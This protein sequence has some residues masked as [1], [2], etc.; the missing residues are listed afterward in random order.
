MSEHRGWTVVGAALAVFALGS[1]M[2]GNVTGVSPATAAA[3]TQ[4]G[5]NLAKKKAGKGTLK[6]VVSGTGTGTYTVTGKGFRRTGQ[7]SK[8]F[9]V[10]PGSYT[11]KPS[12]GSVKPGTV[13]VRK[14]KVSQ[15]KVAFPASVT[16]I[17]TATP[18]TPDPPVT[19]TPSPTTPT[20]DPPVTT[21]PSP[22]TPPPGASG[23]VQ[24]VSVDVLGGE[25]HDAST[26]G[27]WSPDG[28]KV[29]FDSSADNL[30][31]G[32]TNGVGDL[33]VKTLSSGAIQRVST[34]ATGAQ[35]NAASMGGSWSPD[36][37][38]I[39][40]YSSAG[41][42]VAGDTNGAGDLFVKTLSSG[43]IQRV[44]TDATGAQANGE[45]E[46]E[47]VWSPDGTKILFYSSAGNLVAGDTNGALDL[48]VK[49]LSSGAIQRVNTDAT[50]AQ[51]N[52]E[53]DPDGVWSPDG[54]KILFDSSASNLVAGDTNFQDDAF[55]KTLSSGAIQRISTDATGAQGNASSYIGP[56]SP[57]GAKVLF[58]S[59][60][61]NLVAGDTNG[62]GDLFVKTLSSG[63]VQRFNTDATGAQANA[64][65]MG[66]SWSPD[67][68][69]IFFH[70]FAGNLV[71][72]DTNGAIDVFVKTLSS[73]AVEWVSA[74]ATG[75]QESA[76]SWGISWS[77]DG[78]KILFDSSAG[79]LVAGDTNGVGDLFVKAL[80]SGAVQR[81]ST[82][83]TGAQ[84]NAVSLG[85]SW[86]PDGTRILFYSS[87]DNLVA[88][89]TNG[90]TD[91]F[92]KTLQ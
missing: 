51:A 56:W 12:S 19:T 62:V 87:A 58:Y 4:P 9:K 71:A 88:G 48:F 34:D 13:K 55:V 53:S 23:P 20:P 80:S 52:G 2:L 18:T 90:R 75:A 7:T 31:A 61:S 47:G 54:T 68:T 67:G 78:A 17:P 46:P 50:G 16:P 76:D 11:I 44:N 3:A 33:F 77:P 38:K 66:G 26:G 89:D 85:G 22:T 10:K 84:A 24:R 59:S 40:F 45:S 39:L 83:A 72:G 27:G 14:G 28:N 74:N 36:G 21:T 5:S 49:T 60:A 32:D 81:V 8:S 70:S 64:V 6:I 41:N 82:D 65:S 42:L 63:A 29:L 86:S 37:T 92:V 69:K 1:T 79:N 43:A 91:V 25:A 15:V 73:G 35:A 30:V 57:D